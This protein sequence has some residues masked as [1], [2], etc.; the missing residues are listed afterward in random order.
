MYTLNTFLENGW[1][2]IDFMYMVTVFKQKLY[3]GKG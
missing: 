2:N 3:F 1:V